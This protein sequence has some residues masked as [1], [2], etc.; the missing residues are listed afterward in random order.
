MADQPER[1]NPVLRV[2]VRRSG[3]SWTVVSRTR[4]PSMTLPASSQLPEGRGRAVAGFWYEAADADGNVIY[5]RV[6]ED[7]TQ[8]SAEVPSESGEL[9]RIT[10]DRPEVVF[11]VLVPDLPEVSEIRLFAPMKGETVGQTA[12]WRAREPLARLPAREDSP[13][14]Q[15]SR[16]GRRS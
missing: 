15:Q 13:P 10:V 11:N 6:M 5:R 2:R 1:G 4:V 12:R 7:P 14:Q 9:Q 16:R 8:D 3:N